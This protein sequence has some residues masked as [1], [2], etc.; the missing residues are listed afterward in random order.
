MYEKVESGWE[1]V[2][3]IKIGKENKKYEWLIG[4]IY[5]KE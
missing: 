3:F 1:D 5:L 4:S 2:C